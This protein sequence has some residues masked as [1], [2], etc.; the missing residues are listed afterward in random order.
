M[1]KYAIKSNFVTSSVALIL[2]TN[3]SAATVPVWIHS[4]PRSSAISLQISTLELALSV[5][6]LTEYG[7]PTIG[8]STPSGASRIITISNTGALPALNVNY[9]LEST[10]PSNTVITPASCGT[11][12]PSSSCVLTIQPGSS[13]SAEVGVINPAPII[14]SIA[15]SNT[16]IS[17]VA[18]QVLTYG[19]Y[20][21]GGYV[22]AFDDSTTTTASVG[23]KVMTITDAPEMNGIPWSSNGISN[24]TN[25]SYDI[26]PGI[27]Q[28][29][30][31]SAGIPTYSEA[32]LYYNSTYSNA[33]TYPF[34]ASIFF[35]QCNGNIDGVCNSANIK[36]LYNATYEGI[37]Y[38][39][40][41]YNDDYILN[42]GSISNSDYA[43][44]KCAEIISGFSDWYL[45]AI[46][47]LGYDGQS[48]GTGCGIPPASPTLQNVQTSLVDTL[49]SI[50]PQQIAYWSS[51]ASSTLH[52]DYYAYYQVLYPAVGY[53][54]VSQKNAA[55]YIRCVR[56]F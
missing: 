30:T 36:A 27:G 50:A 49:L 13:P 25:Y 52:P 32:Q 1:T 48:K 51:T 39:S 23:G 47:E 19:S 42:P 20:Y 37:P 8:Q 56:S 6:G 7:I 53:Q 15:G 35:R 34:P 11:I 22:F 24:A 45:P 31:A 43:A 9:T 21:Q 10:L 46:C 28:T 29:S 2:V 38:I 17:H 26:I 41:H 14:L 55:L 5:T 40:T 18:I 44:G 4:S 3:L 16:N 12:A 33:A 54:T